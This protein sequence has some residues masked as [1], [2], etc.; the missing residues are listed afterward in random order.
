MQTGASFSEE[1]LNCKKKKKKE[2]K[3]E[4]KLPLSLFA[5][6]FL[7]RCLFPSGFAVIPMNQLHVQESMRAPFTYSSHHCMEGNLRRR[8]R[9]ERIPIVFSTQRSRLS[10]IKE[11][12]THGQATLPK[13]TSILH[14]LLRDLSHPQTFRFPWQAY[15]RSMLYLTLDVQ[16][17]WLGAGQ[18]VAGGGGFLLFQDLCPKTPRGNW[19]DK[20]IPQPGGLSPPP[21]SQVVT[22]SSGNKALEQKHL[23][24]PASQ[25]D[26]KGVLSPFCEAAQ[27][28]W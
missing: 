6:H 18:G 12:H 1:G 26:A 2:R 28:W 27:I 16:W 24:Q 7:V 9:G 13:S 20:A 5:Q 10:E 23:R 22:A 11:A 4:K 17:Q 8:R 25:R 15:N 19:E 21:G 14:L 3:K